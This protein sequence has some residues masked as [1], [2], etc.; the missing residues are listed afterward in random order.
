MTLQFKD[1]LAAMR[2]RIS[3]VRK[4]LL[5]FASDAI[6]LVLYGRIEPN[7]QDSGSNWPFGMASCRV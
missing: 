4:Y 5:V 7:S 1:V 2:K 3:S 6:P